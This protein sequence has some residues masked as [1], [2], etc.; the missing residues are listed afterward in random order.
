[1]G[2]V[3]WHIIAKAVQASLLRE[4]FLI[5]LAKIDQMEGL[6]DD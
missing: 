5:T 2:M 3:S 6:L 4:S 1:M